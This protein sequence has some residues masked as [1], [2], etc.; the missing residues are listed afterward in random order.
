MVRWS[1]FSSTTRRV[2]RVA[3]PMKGNIN[4]VYFSKKLKQ[5]QKTKTNKKKNQT[6]TDKKT[7]KNKRKRKI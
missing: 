4:I 1:Y 2:T 5:Q 7:N 6:K 3:H